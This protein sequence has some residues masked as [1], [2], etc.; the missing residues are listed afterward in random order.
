MP[1]TIAELRTMAEN[2]GGAVPPAHAA[3]EIRGAL[4]QHTAL[5]EQLVAR[6]QQGRRDLFASEQRTFDALNAEADELQR[7]LGLVDNEMARRDA[8]AGGDRAVRGSG[9]RVLSEPRTYSPDAERRGASFLRDVWRGDHGDPGARER[10]GRHQQEMADAYPE[11]RDAGTGAFAG[12]VVPQYLVDLVAPLARAGRPLA[13]I[14]NLHP[15]PPE[16]MTVNIS[17]ITTGATAGAQASEN[18][19]VSEQDMDDTLL[20]VNVRTIAGQQDVSRQAVDRGA[21]VD[22]IALADL[23]RAYHTELDRQI[24]NSDGTSGTHL[25]IRST[26]GIV[27]VTYTDAT[28]TAA[29]LY[30]KLFDLVQQIQAGS[31]Q[32]VSHLV[33]HPRRWW[34]L[35]A[36]VGTSFP[37]LQLAGAP[38]GAAGAILGTGSYEQG[39]AGVLATVGVILDGNIPVN[40]GG[41]TNEDVILGV[42]AEELHLWEDPGAPLFIRSDEVLANQLTVRFVL[43]GYSAFTA[44]RYPGAHGT[45]SGTGLAT[46][47]F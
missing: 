2:A 4:H 35:A 34:K 17:R 10:L 25:G 3:A 18:A 33:M 47:T 12:L 21:G 23:A 32:G 14:A 31:F 19:Q 37:F 27:A 43:Y 36:E 1:R 28:P 5:M 24:I 7:L 46:P 6:A 29:E 45:I 9:V 11:Y 20:A 8:A 38:Q 13:N 40:L 16:G 42:T 30:P 41:G 39:P 26:A 44:G 15:L 22:S